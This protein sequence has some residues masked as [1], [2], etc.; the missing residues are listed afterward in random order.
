MEFSNTPSP[1]LSGASALLHHMQSS[2]ITSIISGYLI[3][4]HRYLTTKLTSRF[5]EIQASIVKQL[6]LIRL[7]SIAMAFMYPEH[8][9]R[10]VTLN[11]VNW[12]RK[13]SWIITDTSIMYYDFG[14][15]ISG[16]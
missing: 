12:L 13:D 16:N 1:I 2:G 3:H 8:D 9:S 6:H 5:W 11:F 14:D 10:A 15:S 7:L 4:S